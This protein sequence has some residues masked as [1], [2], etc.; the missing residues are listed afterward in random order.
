LHFA[1]VFIM[2]FFDRRIGGFF[3]ARN[4]VVGAAFLFGG[5]LLTLPATVG[6][7]V[8]A[9]W[10][11]GTAVWLYR[12]SR[13]Q[14]AG[15]EVAREHRPRVFESG[16]VDVTLHVR[17]NAGA[18]LPLLEIGDR[19]LASFETRQYHLVPVL[20]AGWEVRLHYGR[21]VDRHRGLYLLGPVMLRA[22]DP[23]GVFFETAERPCFTHLTVYPKADPLPD[24][25]V[26][27]PRIMPGA[28][29]DAV[30]QVG[31][32]EE[33]LGVREY[34]RG[35]PPSRIHWR[36]SARRGR[37]LV[38][39]LDRP[40]QSELAVMLDFTR[41]AR[42]G[43]GAEA[44]TEHAVRAAVSILTRAY[45]A[46]H[47]FSLALAHREAEILPGG[48]GLAHLHL[49][50]DRL[51]VLSPGGETDYWAMAAGRAI[52]LEP[53]S[54]AVFVV[55]AHETPPDDAAR[56][57]ARLA[58][59]G[60]ASDFVLLDERRFMPIYQ[61]QQFDL[62]KGRPEFEALCEG[63]RRVG[64]RVHAMDKTGGKMGTGTAGT[65]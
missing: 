5:W 24:Y 13:R 32:G 7:A 34:R 50:L 25:R 58:A 53:G 61:D 59:Q 60:V 40:I 16:K 49:L 41:R 3:S 14:L 8:L 18:P 33:I 22:A 45:E 47:R 57:V 11:I 54:R 19:F 30:A 17:R 46:R 21:A 42:F 31:Q 26:P 35:D 9:G 62:R 6:Q 15:V 63:L 1:L 43:L 51:A 20:A 12:I 44:T 64:A 65:E 48:A 10:M 52:Q 2:T 27:G 36:T 38:L 39:Q 28:S 4:V 23:L 56:L 55:T 37:L 29:V